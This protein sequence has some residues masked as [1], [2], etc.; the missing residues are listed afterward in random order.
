MDLIDIRGTDFCC[1]EAF[2]LPLE[3]QGLVW[4]TG[5]NRDTKAAD[6]NGSGKSSLFKAL[7]WGLYGQTIDGERGD[8]VIR[9]GQKVAHVEVEFRDENGGHWVVVRERRKATPLLQLIKPDGR[10]FKASKEA[11]QE[12]IISMAGL[13]FPA[14]K[15]T[16]LYGQN[17]SARFAH[18]RTKDAERKEM[19]HRILRTGVLKHC[20]DW[21]LEQRRGLKSKVI[22]IEASISNTI[23]KQ[24]M[25]D[26]E[27]L[28]AD[29]DAFEGRRRAEVK[30][31]RD[32]ARISKSDAEDYLAA[33]RATTEPSLDK[34]Q[35]AN[36]IKRLEKLLSQA[37]T[38]ASLAGG[39]A[40]NIEE[41]TEERIEL[42]G[43][44]ARHDAHISGMKSTLNELEGEERCPTCTSPLDE[45]VAKQHLEAV[46]VALKAER[47]KR[48]M[49][50]GEL[51][52]A[53]AELKR[54]RAEKDGHDEKASTAS[55]LT[56]SIRTAEDEMATLEAAEAVAEAAA[57]V[58]EQRAAQSIELARAAILRARTLKEQPN[59]HEDRYKK[60]KS[61]A[62]K[63]KK[64]RRGLKAER[65]EVTTEMA[66]IEFWVRGFSNQGL[67]S[68]ILDA[69]MP[70]IGTRANQ[71]LE[72]L[73][74]SDIQ[75]SFS[76]Q[77]EMKSSKGE[78]RDEID[79]GWTIEGLEDSYP[80][81]GGQL[82]KMEVA[83]DLALM[84]LVAAR[85]GGGLDVLALDEVL[86]GLDA[87]GRQRVLQ[88]LSDLRSRRGTV[89]VISHESQMS[90]I[91]EK[92][93]TVVKEDGV[94]RLVM[95]S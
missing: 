21:V 76:T 73:A 87:E 44:L 66:Y 6:N 48:K 31:A 29:V 84:D 25:L 11:L 74:D 57:E 32:E 16:V 55:A 9:K 53:D 72:T 8:K 35:I 92:S 12:Q 33:A 54:L 20:H 47:K 45:G 56:A 49:P 24:S 23:S 39:L 10:P 43:Q 63:L 77:R 4:I 37:Q 68:Y 60:A 90:E 52:K 7:T 89:F 91:F 19:L 85:A 70:Y 38:S 40:T 88:L 59:P 46:A 28:K 17:D 65:K 13:D 36:N 81:S 51:R 86:D 75:M 79:I 83:T 42:C 69:V 1:F 61:G 18:P 26:V 82:K 15:N 3:E 71:Y 14:F 50:Q 30:A 93:V 67:P 41:Q 5:E 62:R 34:K 22:G 95:S 94:S 27:G 2:D 58:A 80:P 64:Q 78:Y